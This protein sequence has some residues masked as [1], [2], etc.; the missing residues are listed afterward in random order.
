MMPGMDDQ[1][2]GVRFK[3]LDDVY[4]P[5]SFFQSLS[6]FI[7]CPRNSRN[8]GRSFWHDVAMYISI[9]LTEHL[10]TVAQLRQR[11]S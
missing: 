7:V 6:L 3:P 8:N 5:S 4:V 1:D 11:R 10:L 2:A 9:F